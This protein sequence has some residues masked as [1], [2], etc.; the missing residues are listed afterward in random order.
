MKI[1]SR[2]SLQLG[3][4]AGIT[5]HR[6]V[7]D[8][9]VFA[10][11]KKPE[12]FEGLGS[13]VYL[14][15]ARYLPKGQSGMHPHS[16]IDVISVVLE[17]RVSHEGSL[18]HG[19]DLVAGDVQVQRAGGEGFSHN[20]I[21]PDDAPNRMLQIWALPEVAGQPAQYKSYSPKTKGATRIYGGSENQQDTFASA[22]VMDIVHLDNEDSID[23]NQEALIYVITGQAQL[24]HNGQQTPV[25][26][27]DLI[28]NNA[29]KMTA[30]A[31][32]QLLVVTHN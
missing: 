18:E 19:K 16:E 12:T 14:A 32:L 7:T 4:F 3:G 8:S 9:R 31:Q 11:R 25:K 24:H 13:M 30:T 26:E 21:N 28:S 23:I 22:T 27:G 29:Q 2:D 17:G 1:L 10:G 20:E 5:E 15:D 6:L